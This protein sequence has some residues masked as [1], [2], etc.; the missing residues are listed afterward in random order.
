MP[1]LF[2]SILES[3]LV[4]LVIFVPVARGSAAQTATKQP[5]QQRKQ[6]P[7][8][9]A[10][11][12]SLPNTVTINNSSG[13]DAIIALVGA[14]SMRLRVPN[15]Q[16][17]TAHV[18]S[19]N[20]TIL[21]RYGSKPDEFVYS[22]AVGVAV[23]ET[24]TEH[25]NVKITLPKSPRE[26]SAAHKEFEELE[27]GR[28]AEQERVSD[29]RRKM[30]VEVAG[31]DQPLRADLTIAEARQQL[32][33]L[34]RRRG[35]IQV[36]LDEG[37]QSSREALKEPKGRF[38]TTKEYEERRSRL[39]AESLLLEERYAKELAALTDGYNS[40][41][42][43]IMSRRYLAK[44]LRPK[45]MD[46][47]ADKEVLAVTVRGLAGVFKDSSVARKRAQADQFAV[48]RFPVKRELA[49]SLY[50]HEDKL[51]IEGNFVEVEREP[52]PRRLE[53]VLHDPI[54]GARVASE[55]AGN[56]A[57][58]QGASDEERRKEAEERRRV[59]LARITWTDPQ[60]KLMWTLKDNGKD[61]HWNGADTYCRRLRLG[62]FSDWRLP[63]IDELENIYDGRSSEQ[64]K[65]KANIQMSSRYWVAWS[66][67]KNGAGSAM[68]F[69]F[70][71]GHRDTLPP[72]ALFTYTRALCVRRSGE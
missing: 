2:K 50:E 29:L 35:E 4:G 8:Q 46:Y 61:V 57:A 28:R 40:R 26:D 15:G 11:P 64:H 5:D 16:V 44:G 38:E 17:V 41:I 33:A 63:T 72:L 21:V 10:I 30:G 62:E 24:A 65:V 68:S 49:R 34:L 52:D 71:N 31:P 53:I 9:P 70:A 67:T 39:D 54:T 1:R 23:T 47:D 43:E 66:A 36:R 37:Y 60:T 12:E 3:G 56:K 22:R 51:E 7:N 55:N 27:G 25:S 32:V 6:G 13:L 18:A 42:A 45:L 20:Y 58:G 48:W 14:S 19:G 69:N 59:E